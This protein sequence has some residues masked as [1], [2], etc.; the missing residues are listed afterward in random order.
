MKIRSMAIVA[1][2]L[3]AILLAACETPPENKNETAGTVIGAVV[4]GVVGSQ[5][6]GGS[7]R[8]VAGVVGAAAGGFI[9]HSIGKRMDDT[10]HMKARQA[11]ENTKTGESTTWRNPDTGGTY[12]VTPTR[13]Y[14][15]AQGPCREYTL[16]GRVGEQAE[17]VHGTAC[18]QDDGGWQAQ[19]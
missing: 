19:N 4:G 5:V 9:G 12:T 18:R 11:L 3:P 10:D 2:V 6:G 7:G 14:Q 16:D 15:A 1:G 8:V 17:K 13:T